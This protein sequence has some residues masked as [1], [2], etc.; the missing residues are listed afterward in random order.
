MGRW[1]S[2]F[3]DLRE[4]EARPVVQSFL[5]LFLLIG[6]HTTLET[7]RDA[8]F[9]TKLPPSRLNL[10]YIALAGLSFVVAALSTRL[11]ERFGRRNALIGTL[12][13]AAVATVLL[14]AMTPTPRVVMALYVFSGLVGAVLS[15]QFWLLAA[16]MFTSAQGRRVFGPIASGGVVG[17]VA[18]A[19]TAAV[20][21]ARHPVTSLL[22]VAGFAFVATALLLT[23]LALPI[24]EADLSAK[25]DIAIAPAAPAVKPSLALKQQPFVWRVALLV[26]LSTAA[27]LALDYLFKSTA[28][29]KIP[30]A[31]LGEFFARYYAVMNGVSLVVQ[32][33]VA[34]RIVRR[35]G[36]AAATGVMPSLL[37]LGGVASFVTGGALFPVLAMRMIDGGLRHSLN[38]VATELLY[39]PMPTAVRERA[40]GLIDTVLSRSVQ[41]VTAAVLFGL[42][43]AGILSPRMLAAIVLALCAAWTAVAASLRTPYLDVFRR[44]LSRGTLQLGAETTE[45]DVNAAEALVEAMA[46][47]EPVQVVAALDVLAQRNREK[48]IPALVLYHDSDVVL[49]RALEIFG[50]SSRAD[51]I[52][53]GERLLSHPEESVRIAALRA[54]A[55][56]GVASALARATEDSS[57]T[58]QA[59]AVLYLAL[60]SDGEDLAR[61]PRLAP[62]VTAGDPAGHARRR[63]LLTAI[64]DAADA[65][66]TSL[67]LAIA[68]STTFGKTELDVTLLARAMKALHDPRYVPF[69]VAQLG[70]RPGRE[71]IRQALVAMAEPALDA[72]E[73]ALLDT[74]TDRR[75]R[76]HIPRTI[77][78]FG[79]QRACDFLMARLVEEPDGFVRYKVLRGLGHIVASHEVKVDRRK[80]EAEARRNLVEYLRLTAHRVAIENESRGAPLSPSEQL[81]VGLLENKQM[82]SM[83]RAF[84]LLKIAHRREDIHRVH[85]AARSHD[86]RARS[87]AGEFLDT[88]LAG[89]S[90]REL[91][92]LFRLVVDDLEPATRVR[93]AAGYL[94]VIPRDRE[95]ALAA[96]VQDRDAG[97]ATLSRYDAPLAGTG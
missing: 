28:A 75:V 30:P 64:A 43:A 1:I 42:A 19:T 86:K 96:L 61:H 82:Q 35:V 84:R 95:Q 38:R 27:V 74:A 14:H 87:N 24:D 16:Q 63:V 65:R 62:M 54:L 33:F 55:K 73:T 67:V 40:K 47:P 29:L 45:I 44:A 15:P 56:H 18:G 80:V 60:R 72:L 12:C 7:A 25:L 39:L 49:F 70:T 69:C 66:A 76:T 68:R 9:L 78:D 8:L 85:T 57:A 21:L 53:L 37:L 23:T 59:Y 81:L 83:E 41:A 11:A 22:L 50:A 89:R 26:G 58:V 31:R 79:T 51:W 93:R 71:A 92:A 3:F 97:I 77:A 48:L 90:Q 91:R 17:G 52:P 46:S 10:V 36:V 2:R 5:V 6:A 20:L 4:G 34:G 32:L 13:L 88:L 94:G